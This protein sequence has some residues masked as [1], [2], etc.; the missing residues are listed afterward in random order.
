MDKERVRNRIERLRVQDKQLSVLQLKV[1]G[2]T[3]ILSQIYKNLAGV[4]SP[5]VE[6]AY[7]IIKERDE[8]KRIAD[9]LS[10]LAKFIS[11][12]AGGV[13]YDAEEIIN[14]TKPTDE[15]K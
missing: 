3:I 2:V 6:A 13:G 4:Q 7:L 11:T 9:D 10:E 8:L 5:E 14:S 1:Q 12:T 15:K